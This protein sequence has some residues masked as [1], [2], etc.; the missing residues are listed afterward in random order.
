MSEDL[1]IKS[2]NT[3]CLLAGETPTDPTAETPQIDFEEQIL[4]SARL[5]NMVLG[6]DGALITQF[7]P[8]FHRLI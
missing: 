7:A 5:R 1:S 3:G 8:E 4:T 6:P 2:G